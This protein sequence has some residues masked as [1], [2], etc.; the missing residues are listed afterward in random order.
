MEYYDQIMDDTSFRL[1][2]IV[3]KMQENKN[4]VLVCPP[5]WAFQGDTANVLERLEREPA[6]TGTH[7]E[8]LYNSILEDLVSAM[9]IYFENRL[10]VLAVKNDVGTM[11]SFSSVISAYRKAGVDV[12]SAPLDLDYIKQVD[13][14]RGRKHHTSERYA[15]R[16]SGGNESLNL[17]QIFQTVRITSKIIRDFDRWI[18]ALYPDFAVEKIES[19]SVIGISF[20]TVN[21][22][23]D[24]TQGGKIVK[25]S[26][27]NKGL[28][29]P[30]NVQFFGIQASVNHRK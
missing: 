6:I 8:Y 22:A 4:A 18:F 13:V 24:M 29:D 30:T 9:L 28:P 3:L 1:G 20:T 12:M 5:I 2:A 15:P 23:Y 17:E 26:S 7:I 11:N 14:M 27:L 21:H 19:D 10:K 16:L 25:R